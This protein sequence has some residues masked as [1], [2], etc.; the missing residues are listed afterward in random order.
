VTALGGHIT[1]VDC[2]VGPIKVR[3]EIEHEPGSANDGDAVYADLDEVLGCSGTRYYGD[4]HRLAR[5]DIEDVCLHLPD[6]AAA[7]MISVSEPSPA[8]CGLE[9]DY[10]PSLS[11]I[12]GIVI[13]G[14]MAQALLYGLDGLKRSSTRTLWMRRVAFRSRTP[15]QPVADPFPAQLAATKNQ[16]IDRGGNRWRAVELKTQMLG[17]SGEFSIAHSLPN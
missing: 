9:A 7:A 14:Q 6:A 12:D 10:R 8:E 4:R 5:R 16:L 15:Y 2:G 17:M 1:T 3:C 11:G 13:A